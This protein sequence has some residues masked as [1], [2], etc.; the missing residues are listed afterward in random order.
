MIGVSRLRFNDALEG[1]LCFVSFADLRVEAGQYASV[2]KLVR[3]EG[4]DILIHL[5]CV[6][7]P[8]FSAIKLSQR[9]AQKNIIG[10]CLDAALEELIRTFQRD[11]GLK[12][13]FHTDGEPKLIDKDIS[14]L[15]YLA[16][17]E[18]LRNVIKHAKAKR[19]IVETINLGDEMQVI[20]SDDGVGLDKE[21]V[22]GSK[23]S[24][25]FGLFGIRELMR[26]LGGRL[27]AEPT[28]K[29]SRIVLSVPL[30]HDHTAKEA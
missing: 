13:V 28:A 22:S 18:L 11:Y 29:G 24:K 8:L 3:L 9:K 5:L 26:D 2:G 10:H 20:V 27:E 16:T 15:L 25:G 17:Y 12:F 6:H 14:V 1:L 7:I 30:G 21:I 23:R 19:G 4:Y